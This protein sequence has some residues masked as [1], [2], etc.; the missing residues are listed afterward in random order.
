MNSSEVA[1]LTLGGDDDMLFTRGWICT[2]CAAG[3]LRSCGGL[4]LKVRPGHSSSSSPS[5]SSVSGVWR[6]GQVIAGADGH[7]GEHVVHE[8][9]R[10]FGH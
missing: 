8:R 7:A 2:R 5:P 1:E 6:S 4:E 10:D 3:A 9:G